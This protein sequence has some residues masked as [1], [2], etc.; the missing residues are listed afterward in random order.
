VP[1]HQST[2]DFF[3]GIRQE[4]SFA[5]ERRLADFDLLRKFGSSDHEVAFV[6]FTSAL[7]FLRRTISD[8][9]GLLIPSI[10]A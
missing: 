5:D 6:S 2:G 9:R 1:L 3:N 10:A 7:R 8:Q 4:R